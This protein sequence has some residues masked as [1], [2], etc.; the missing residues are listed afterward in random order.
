MS[1]EWIVSLLVAALIVSVLAAVWIRK[2]KRL[3]H[4]DGKRSTVSG[5]P[6]IQRGAANNA[7]A[8]AE[9]ESLLLASADGQE[10]ALTRPNMMQNAEKKYRE[11]SIRSSSALGQV[12]QGA[13]PMLAQAQTL[14]QIIKV[15]PNGLFTATGSVQDLMRYSDGTVASF[16]RKGTQF[17]TH[18]GFTEIA[19]NQANPAAVIG[20][21]MAAMAMV[22]GQYYMNEISEQLKHVEQKLD[23]LIG[24]HH[25]EKIGILKNVNRELFALA[26]KSHTDAA[27]IIACQRLCEKC[28]EVYYE[29]HTRLEGVSVN[30][31]ERWINKVRE[32]RELGSSIDDSEL[33][34]TIQM[35]YQ[36][37]A[38]YEKCKLA[39]ISVR[40]KIGGSQERFISEQLAL[41]HE[42]SKDAFHRNIHQYIDNHYAPLLEKSGKIAD[43]M[44][45]PLLS[46]VT[47]EEAK[48]IR[49][50]KEGILQMVANDSVDLV[51]GLVHS[52]CEPKE[53]LI[54]LE[55][56]PDGQR[57]FVLDES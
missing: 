33:N 1:I 24:Y 27:D 9:I 4:A 47:I 56:S 3:L 38:L 44:K 53:M 49:R 21:A 30:A 22:S 5:S 39:E 35:C 52:L 16:V 28:G 42:N 12:A 7:I 20:G 17:G 19:I 29:Y 37:S 40:M 10:L 34:F 6:A 45:L 31:K 11:I 50:K 15:A 13:M 57:V 18:S 8:I 36:A 23:K 51:Q 48:N 26:S 41:L 32:L 54:M 14:N 55:G 2:R 25:D 43:A 46:N